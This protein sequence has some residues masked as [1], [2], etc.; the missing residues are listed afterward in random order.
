M[1]HDVR[2][3]TK[4]EPLVLSRT[5]AAP[6]SLVFRA[7]STADHMKRWFSPE[8]YSVP[9]AEIDFRPGGVCDICMR[10]PGGDDS[11]C[12]GQFVEIVRPERLVMT[13]DVS[14]DG[15]RR[16]IAHTTVTFEDD[17][18]GTR[19][20]VRQAYEIFDEA[21][22]GAVD[23]APAG[24]RTTLDKLEREVARM[25]TSTVHSTF[26]I[27]RS[28]RATQAQVFHALSDIDAKGRWF[29]GGGDYTLLERTMDVR[30]GGR[31]R[32]V[33]R[34]K[35]GMIVTFDA[36]YFDVV[37]NRRLVYAYEMHQDER[38]ISVSLATVELRAEG[39]QTRLTLTEQGAFLDGYDDNDAR[40][41]GTM[42]LLDRLGASLD[43]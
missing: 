26:T 28:Y 16:F 43:G 19:M 30:P 34:W 14:T 13:M 42:M 35:S 5:F 20:S 12:R 38:K 18:A 40:E 9:E 21:F 33:G 23:G 2:I 3:S 29:V 39:T 32:L 4:P 31:E 37:P 1:T 22:R 36:T 41:R 27:E 8:G 17:G 11:W 25:A 15:I 6:R 10:S 24:W 7:W